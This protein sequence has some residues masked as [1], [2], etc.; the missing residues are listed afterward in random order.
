MDQSVL[1]VP[2]K[3]SPIQHLTPVASLAWLRGK[4]F[5]L[6]PLGVAVLLGLLI[7]TQ[8]LASGTFYLVTLLIPPAIALGLT[9]S[10]TLW[11]C[12][13]LPKG[14]AR[15]AWICISLA[16]FCYFIAQCLVAGLS[17]TKFVLPLLLV[18]DLLIITF[19]PLLISGLLL[20]PSPSLK[21]GARGR[22]LVEVGIITLAAL[23]L[24]FL[25]IIAP[26]WNFASNIDMPGTVLLTVY[27]LGDVALI[28]TIVLLLLRTTE[29]A[30]RPVFFWM[31][32]GIALFVYNDSALYILSL[33]NRVLSTSPLINPFAT[34]GELLMGLSAWF[35]L[36]HGGEPGSLWAWLAQ[37]RETSARAPRR[38]WFLQYVFPYFPLLLL[39]VF[40]VV[41]EQLPSSEQT[42]AYILEGLALAVMLLA[43]TRQIILNRDLVDAQVAN[44]RAQQLDAL[45]DQFITSVNHELR[46][47]LMTMQTYVE[48]LRYR[49]K[50]LPERSGK[51]IEAIGRTN[52]A[53]VDLVQSIL[54][55]RRLDQESQDFAHEAV[56]LHRALEHA[57]ALINPREGNIAERV[58]QVDLPPGL[59]VWG[60][61]VRVQQM[62][63]NLLSN[64]VKYS[65]P[66]STIEV[67]AR[68]VQ[69]ESGKRA[70]SARQRPVVEIR[71]RDYGL[72]I[73]PEQIPLLFHR[74]VRLPRDLASNVVGSGLGLY[75]CWN[76]AKGMDGNIWVESA[77]IPGNGS[78][79]YIQLPLAVAGADLSQP[80]EMEHLL[81][82]V[83]TLPQKL[84]SA[85]GDAVTSG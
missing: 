12:L 65:P 14:Q 75:L 29:S 69:P 72:G 22:L 17:F 83:G 39:C 5:L 37:G 7:L 45:K 58:L 34:G 8:A 18:A 85:D 55:V 44:E 3:P 36:V 41:R 53:L 32:L 16:F 27:P 82:G 64:A 4:H 9:F 13:R 57:I 46:T 81:A 49:Q 43:I 15:R 60:E 76:L 35:Y 2:L 51:L 77:G 21:R 31:A 38:R 70:K 63:T 48:L 79:F 66:D 61:N 30:M 25:T 47:P 74:F 71:I 80:A 68:V 33:H 50:E 54:E 59:M 40:L 42:S 56:N 26:L 24:S 11:V 6:L 84:T 52:D 67:S 62:L 78:T 1:D 23:G 10:G 20:L 73:P 28:A 19:Y